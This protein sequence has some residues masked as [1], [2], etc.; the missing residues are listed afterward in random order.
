MCFGD[1]LSSSYP[2]CSKTVYSF[3][4]TLCSK[5]FVAAKT[6]METIIPV[7]IIPKRPIMMEIIRDDFCKGLMSPYPTVRAVI[8]DQ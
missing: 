7:K 4:I 2:L 8:N 5:A 1:R 3:G 6:A